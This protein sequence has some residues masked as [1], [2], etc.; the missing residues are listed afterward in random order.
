MCSCTQFEKGLTNMYTKGLFIF[1]IVIDLFSAL[2]VYTTNGK[3]VLRREDKLLFAANLVS[4]QWVMIE[5]S[6]SRII[7]SEISEKRFTESFRTRSGI[8]ET[9]IF[10]ECRNPW[11][12]WSMGILRVKFVI[13]KWHL[14]WIL[15]D[16]C[17]FILSFHEIVTVKRQCDRVHVYILYI[18]KK[19]L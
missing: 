13:D 14:N 1:F 16:S 2:V 4:E 8:L 12:V 11:R 18:Y 9:Y 10:Q 5:D 3:Q 15:K 19:F 6:I 7:L 17:L